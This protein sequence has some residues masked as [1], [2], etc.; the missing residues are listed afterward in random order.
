MADFLAATNDFLDKAIKGGLP[1]A[2]LLKS[3]D[4][5]PGFEHR[6]TPERFPGYLDEVRKTLQNS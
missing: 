2:E 3:H 6:K 5:V 1:N 4:F